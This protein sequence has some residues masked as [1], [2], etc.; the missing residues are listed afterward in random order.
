MCLCKKKKSE[1]HICVAVTQTGVNTQSFTPLT[2]LTKENICEWIEFRHVPKVAESSKSHT[3][4][5]LPGRKADDGGSSNG[6]QG[7]LA[8]TSHTRLSRSGGFFFGAYTHVNA[9]RG[10]KSISLS[11]RVEHA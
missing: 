9:N 8:H 10:G 4:D 5:L 7:I 6:L 1:L 2:A 11:R 3:S